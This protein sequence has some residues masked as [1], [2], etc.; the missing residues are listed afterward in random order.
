MS[1]AVPIALFASILLLGI[2]ALTVV[3]KRSARAGKR[4]PF[5][6]DRATPLWATD[7]GSDA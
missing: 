1:Y 4:T 5:S 3:S 2:I 6:E 7:E